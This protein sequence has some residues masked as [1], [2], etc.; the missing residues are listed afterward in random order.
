MQPGKR[1]S[2]AMVDQRLLEARHGLAQDRHRGVNVE[3]GHR[4]K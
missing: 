4:A 2:A 3:V 1:Y